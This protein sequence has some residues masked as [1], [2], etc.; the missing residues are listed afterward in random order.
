[1]KTIRRMFTAQHSPDTVDDW[2]EEDASIPIDNTC[3]K[4]DGRYRV[5]CDIQ[6]VFEKFLP[7]NTFFHPAKDIKMENMKCN[8]REI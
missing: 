2:E 7:E 3:T 5:L 4:N 1:M 8:K 6:H